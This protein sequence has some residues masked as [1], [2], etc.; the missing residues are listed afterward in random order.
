MPEKSEFIADNKTID[1]IKQ[2]IG[3]DELFYQSLDDLIHSTSNATDNPPAGFD[4]SCF[5]GIYVTGD[6]SKE[7][8]LKLE[9]ARNDS[10]KQK[11][12]PDEEVL[13]IHND[14]Q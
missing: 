2:A 1:E 7:Y 6:V 5:D 4:S 10:A 12:N 8:L 9:E 13:D 11:R 14:Q 3:A